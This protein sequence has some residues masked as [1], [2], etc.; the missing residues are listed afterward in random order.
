MV[1]WTWA[2]A[3]AGVGDVFSRLSGVVIG[4]QLVSMTRHRHQELEMKRW[5]G[6]GGDGV[7][8]VC[9]VLFVGEGVC[10][11]SLYAKM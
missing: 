8:H 2:G 7:C 6:W 9:V 3:G 10:W 11:I 4:I 5:V 1:G